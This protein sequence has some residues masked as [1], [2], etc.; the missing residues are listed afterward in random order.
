MDHRSRSRRSHCGPAE[1]RSEAGRRKGTDTSRDWVAG[2]KSNIT[3][4]TKEPNGASRSLRIRAKL[5]V[6]GGGVFQCSAGDVFAPSHVKAVGILPSGMLELVSPS[7]SGP[8]FSTGG[9]G[10]RQPREDRQQKRCR[11]DRQGIWE[12]NCPGALRLSGRGHSLRFERLAR[13]AS[14]CAIVERAG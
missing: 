12:R 1:R 11:G 14:F 8:S 6:A 5:L 9:P 13:P 7:E 4:C 10:W 3:Q 2:G